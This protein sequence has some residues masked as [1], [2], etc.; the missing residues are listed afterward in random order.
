[1]LKFRTA[2]ILYISTTC[3]LLLLHSFFSFSLWWLLLPLFLFKSLLIYGSANIHSSFYANV[4][5]SG[6]TTEK[7]IAITFDDGPDLNYTP[8]VLNIL[9]EHNATATFF[10]IG[11]KIKGNEDLVKNIHS[12]GNLIG[13]HTF[14]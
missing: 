11:K 12:S 7:K 8:E 10:L 2:S 1:M 4:I 9:K 13:N 6:T 3:I 5:C 14:S